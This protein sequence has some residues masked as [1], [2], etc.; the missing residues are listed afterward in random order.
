MSLLVLFSRVIENVYHYNLFDVGTLIYYWLFPLIISSHRA[1]EHFKAPSP[2]HQHSATT[3][4]PM[5]PNQFNIVHK[6]VN[7]QSR[8]IKE[9]M[10]ICV[11]DPPQQKPGKLPAAAHMGPS[12][13]GITNFPAQANQPANHHIFYIAPSYW[14][15]PPLPS[16][17][18]LL[19]F[20]FMPPSHCPLWEGATYFPFLLIVVSTRVYPKYPPSPYLQ[21]LQQCHLGK[22]LHFI[23]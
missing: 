22:F 5:D 21:V 12:S 3:G 14:F 9:A 19:P 20:P 10:F 16:I 18:S 17:P 6:E 7:S 4:H 15:P 2:I 11:Q 1:K 8:T 23:C 13:P